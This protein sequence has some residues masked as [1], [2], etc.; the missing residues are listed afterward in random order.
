MFDAFICQAYSYNHVV[1]LITDVG[2]QQFGN[3]HGIYPKFLSPGIQL[4]IFSYF[5]LN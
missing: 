4:Y 3:V 1:T 2:S 5:I